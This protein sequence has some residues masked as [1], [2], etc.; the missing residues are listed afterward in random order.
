[1]WSDEEIWPRGNLNWIWL[2]H[3]DAEARQHKIYAILLLAIRAI[4]HFRTRVKLNRFWQSWVFPL[5]ALFGA[6]F[7]LFHDHGAGSGA[8]SPEARPY[9]VSWA[10]PSLSGA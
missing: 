8:S 4:E 2:V 9:V 7:L 5:L 1:M 3:H 6:L 10:A